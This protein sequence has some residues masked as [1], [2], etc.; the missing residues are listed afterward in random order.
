MAKK[1]VE[2]VRAGTEMAGVT[3][4]GACCCLIRSVL[5][6]GDSLEIYN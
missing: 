2:A 3:N 4:A 5:H 6:K 1:E